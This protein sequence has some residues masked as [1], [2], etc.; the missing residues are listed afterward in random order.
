MLTDFVAITDYLIYDCWKSERPDAKHKYHIFEPLTVVLTSS[1]SVSE[2]PTP[3]TNT[4]SV[5]SEQT[6]DTVEH[7][8]L[9]LNATPSLRGIAQ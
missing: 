1:Y 9:L 5:R 8:G 7:D 3:Q 6:T 2:Y 4:R